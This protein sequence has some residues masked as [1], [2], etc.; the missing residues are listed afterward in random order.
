VDNGNVRD[1]EALGM[2][3]RTLPGA[4]TPMADLSAEV[5]TPAARPKRRQRAARPVHS[6]AK[7]P[8]MMS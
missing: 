3:R 8:F 6:T 1:G 2:A 7:I 5:P 4:L